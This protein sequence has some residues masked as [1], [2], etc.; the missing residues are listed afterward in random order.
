MDIASSPCQL[1]MCHGGCGV[2]GGEGFV[3]VLG[4]YKE[5]CSGLDTLWINTQWSYICS[6]LARYIEGGSSHK[7]DIFP[8]VLKISD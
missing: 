2:V 8:S 4:Q 6:F 5:L 1:C 7:F 3:P